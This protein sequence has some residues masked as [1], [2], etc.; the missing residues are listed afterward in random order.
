MLCE[1]PSDARK[2]RCTSGRSLTVYP[3]ANLRLA[4]IQPDTVWRNPEANRDRLADKIQACS[5]LA[6]LIAL[7]ETFASGFGDA[8]VEDAEPMHGD[9]VTW[10]AEMAHAVDAVVTGSVVI[11]DCGQ[12]FNRMLWAAPDGAVGKYDKRHLFRMAGEHQRYAPGRER[13]IFSVLGWRVCAQVCYDL[14][15]PVFSRNRFD[16][17]LGVMDYDL[18]LYVANWPAVR[19][20]AWQRLLPARAIEN[21][22]YCAGVN[23]VGTDG[24]GIAYAGDS[25]VLDPLGEALAT[26][27]DQETTLLATLSR[28]ELDDW[29][30]RFPGYLDA[31]RFALD[32]AWGRRASDLD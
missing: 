23:R 18:L 32:Y 15:F 24:Q 21:L 16:A 12:T 8:V 20:Q 4:L 9:T 5:G 17:E 19:R 1:K 7:P 25:V 14:R 26:A 10:L 22:S 29:R 11:R 30:Q 2:R 31:D 27:D 13:Q 28:P 6:D 3:A